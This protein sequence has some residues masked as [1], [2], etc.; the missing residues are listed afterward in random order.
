ML[1]V[2]EM[3]C[4]IGLLPLKNKQQCLDHPEVVQQLKKVGPNQG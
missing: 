1:A 2:Q 3:R 4:W